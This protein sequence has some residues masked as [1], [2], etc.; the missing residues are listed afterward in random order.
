MR[1]SLF[2]Q[3][4]SNGSVYR[5]FLGIKA[6]FNFVIL[7]AGLECSHSF[8][9][10]YIPTDHNLEKRH[11]IATE[12]MIKIKQQCLLIDDDIRWLIALIFDTGLRL[13]EAAGLS[14][15]DLKLDPE[16]PHIALRFHPHR[17]LKTA[18]SARK[19]PLKVT[20]LWA[21]K[22]LKQHC[23]GSYCFPGHTSEKLCNANSASAAINKCIKTLT[24]KNDVTHGL[25]HSFRDRP[26]A[27]E[28]QTDMICIPS[29]PVGLN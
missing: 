21:A 20:S 2:K 4:F 10:V 3:G 29:A 17:R 28:A 16:T 5:V 27:I 18:P 23:N 24:D 1:D 9:K 7:E 25:R 14:I 26:R 15:D 13:S 11:S 12:N 6:I 22:R 8:T 19:I